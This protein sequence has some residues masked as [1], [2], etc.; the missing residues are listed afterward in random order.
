MSTLDLPVQ[1]MTCA[2]CANRIERK[3]NKLDGVTATVNYATEQASVQYDD[4]TVT[5][6][7][8]VAAVQAAG[9]SAVL[10]TPAA[11]QGEQVDQDVPAT[12]PTAA[13]RRRL[14]VSWLLTLPVLAM[15]MVPALQ[16][17]NWQWVALQLTTPVVLW[18]AWPF[19]RAAWANLRLGTASMDTL[20]SLGAL[21]SWV[22]SIVVLLTTAAGDTGFRMPFSLQVGSH[23]LELQ[24]CHRVALGPQH[25][26][27]LAEDTQRSG[28]GQAAYHRADRVGEQRGVRR[29]RPHQR[30]ERVSCVELHESALV[31]GGR[32]A[33]QSEPSAK[34]CP[35]GGGGNGQACSARGPH[36]SG[37][38]RDGGDQ[39][40]VRVVEPDSVRPAAPGRGVLGSRGPGVSGGGLAPR[41]EVTERHPGAVGAALRSNRPGL[42][43][44]RA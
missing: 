18:G 15:S 22:Y 4:A 24:R 14:V 44:A 32:H 2:S 37:I 19:H 43:A 30:P 27:H 7:D 21:V 38:S 10:P 17:D 26:A 20:V 42:L 3:L 8:L 25:V 40:A 36:I 6:Q 1:G 34:R 23:L 9:Y 41:A 29:S 35:V 11:E 13:L 28:L 39:L 31:A 5:P 12:D 16:F 33:L